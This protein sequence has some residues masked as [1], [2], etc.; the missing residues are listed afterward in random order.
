M[1]VGESGGRFSY[2]QNTGTSTAPAFVAATGTANALNG[3]DV[4]SASSPE[5]VDLDGDFDVDAMVGNL[6]GTVVYFR[7]TGSTAAPAFLEITS[8]SPF[9][10]IDVGL[11]S[12]PGLGDLDGDGDFDAVVGESNGALLYFRNTGASTAPAFVAVNGTGNPTNGFTVAQFSSAKLVDLDGDGDFDAVIGRSN[13][14]VNYFENTG[15]SSVPAYVQRVGAP[16]PFNGIDVGDMSNTEHVDLDGDGDRDAIIGNYDGAVRYW[17]NTGSSTVP[18]FVE[19]TGSLNPFDGIDI[20]E[21]AAPELVDLDGD[22]DLDAVLGAHF[23]EIFYFENT[24]SSTAPVF[25][26][27]TGSLNSFDTLPVVGHSTPELVDLDGDGDLDMTT[28]QYDGD[29]LFF[30]NTGSSSAPAFLQRT[31]TDNPFLGIDVARFSAPELADLDADADLDLL[32]GGNGGRVVYFRSLAPKLLSVAKAGTGNGTVS[33]DLVGINCGVDCSESYVEGTVVTLS[34]TPDGS[35]SF[36][37]WSG[38]G[39]SGTGTCILT[40][41]MP[42][43][44]TA[45]FNLESFLLTVNKTGGGSGTVTSSP[46]GINCGGDCTESYAGGTMVTL[47][48]T[49]D[50]GSVFSGWSGGGCSGTAPCVVTMNAAQTVTALIQPEL[51]FEDGFESGNTTAWSAAVP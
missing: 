30:E 3:V 43:S 51:I 5:L 19:R 28:G 44:V 18:T 24:G 50:A 23:G 4:G 7:N 6:T 12:T 29:L 46:A 20:G 16:N 15:S 37:G 2:F 13:G 32:V 26:E 8:A 38:S 22:G 48:A 17:E 11:Q 42:R 40:M 10:G 31:G 21:F 35:S 9:A 34:A 45:T 27:R 14:Q 1:F 41:T 39:C 49:A 47:T 25:V 33:S 36:T